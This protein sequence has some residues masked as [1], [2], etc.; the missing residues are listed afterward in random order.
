VVCRSVRWRPTEDL[1]AR[2]LAAEFLVGPLSEELVGWRRLYRRANLIRGP[3]DLA[4][5]GAVAV[6]LWGTAVLGGLL[7][8][9][10]GP[11]PLGRGALGVLLVAGAAIAASR[12]VPTY[13]PL[14]S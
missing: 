13:R 14:G 11:F 8:V 10:A 9:T 4:L 3:W 6:G 2:Q 12:L 7:I 5:V 1:R